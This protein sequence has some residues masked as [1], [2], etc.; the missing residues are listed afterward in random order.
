[1]TPQ[2]NTSE[3]NTI[4]T[5]FLKYSPTEGELVRNLNLVKIFLE[6]YYFIEGHENSFEKTITRVRDLE[7]V[8]ETDLKLLTDIANHHL[9][10]FT[11]ESF[12]QALDSLGRTLYRLPRIVL[13]IPVRLDYSSLQK[14]SQWI[15]SN[16]SANTLLHIQINPLLVA[17][18]GISWNSMRSEFSVDEKINM[19]KDSLFSL[20]PKI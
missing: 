18:C 9:P 3:I 16:V 13:Q 20:L 6:Q 12:Y 5:L 19:K 15:R 2:N 8:T 10:F 7:N 4:L 1:M 14:I 17:G 11:K